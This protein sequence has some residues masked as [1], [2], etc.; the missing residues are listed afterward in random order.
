MLKV[1]TVWSTGKKVKVFHL[2]K[3]QLKKL[4]S[5]CTLCKFENCGGERVF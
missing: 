4:N 3:K 1:E 2:S 5:C